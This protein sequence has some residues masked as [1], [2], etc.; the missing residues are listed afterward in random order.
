METTVITVGRFGQSL[1][2]NEENNVNTQ[3]IYP[4][5]IILGAV[6]VAVALLFSP[7]TPSVISLTGEQPELGP[8]RQYPWQVSE[9]FAESIWR[10]ETVT[11]E[12]EYCYNDNLNQVVCAQMPSPG[13]S[14]PQRWLLRRDGGYIWRIE[15]LTGRLDFCWWSPP[16]CLTNV[17]VP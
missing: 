17:P 8:V 11:G 1:N 3:S 10:I 4:R 7:G 5:T 6:L 15:T 14:G 9:P 2:C 12:L 16:T 13:L